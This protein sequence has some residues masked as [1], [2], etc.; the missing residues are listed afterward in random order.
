MPPSSEAF[1][2]DAGATATPIGWFVEAVVRTREELRWT[3]PVLVGS[4]GSDEELAALL[5]LPGVRRLDTGA[6]SCDLLA[7]SRASALFG[8]ADSSFS[9][10]ASLLGSVPVATCPAAIHAARTPLAA[11][12]V[13]LANSTKKPAARVGSRPHGSGRATRNV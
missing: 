1:V 12:T 4:D 11:G 3:V 13:C 9:G 5:A 6:A 10:W 7:L 8:S 2:V